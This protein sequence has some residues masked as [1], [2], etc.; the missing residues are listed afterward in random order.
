MPRRTIQTPPRTR[1]RSTRAADKLILITLDNAL[2][3]AGHGLGYGFA[4]TTSSGT[5]DLHKGDTV[6][7]LSS[8]LVYRFIGTS[9]TGRNLATQAYTSDPTNWERV[10]PQVTQA[11]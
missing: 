1:P 3:T 2:A 8:G 10:L 5:K 7:V 9:G 4:Y 11:E 6:K